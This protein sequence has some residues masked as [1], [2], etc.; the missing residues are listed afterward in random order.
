ML[1]ILEKQYFEKNEELEEARLNL[2]YLFMDFPFGEKL[3][4]ISIFKMVDY[5]LGEE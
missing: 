2:L 3:Q 1:K 5:I 4:G